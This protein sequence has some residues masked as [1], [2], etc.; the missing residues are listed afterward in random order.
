[1]PN[2]HAQGT[3][4]REKLKPERNIG[5]EKAQIEQC[6]PGFSYKHNK[7]D[8]LDGKSMEVVQIS[9]LKSRALGTI[10]GMCSSRKAIWPLGKLHDIASSSL[11][12]RTLP[13]ERNSV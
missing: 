13:Q 1:M 5:I 4:T 7:S 3:V 8:F 9:P 10:L 12:L 11:A 6:R 2:Q